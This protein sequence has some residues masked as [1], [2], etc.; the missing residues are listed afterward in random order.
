M[1]SGETSIGEGALG[2]H[3]ESLGDY[4]KK[5]KRI[6]ATEKQVAEGEANLEAPENIRYQLRRWQNLKVGDAHLT[7]LSHEVRS[8]SRDI[9]DVL[10]RGTSELSGCL[11]FKDKA[12]NLA[13][14]DIDLSRIKELEELAKQ[15]LDFSSGGE[16]QHREKRDRAQ[17]ALERYLVALGFN[18]TEVREVE[19]EH[20]PPRVDFP[21]IWETLDY[22]QDPKKFIENLRR[23]KAE[24]DKQSDGTPA[25]ESGPTELK[26]F[27]F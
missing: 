14:V 4:L 5:Y 24:A 6:L 23:V 12:A 25:V 9:G 11:Y 22:L 19:V 17:N 8:S 16:R 15:A 3:P 26:E 13:R 20:S 10:L 27:D 1:L 7:P 18:L 2:E 21:N